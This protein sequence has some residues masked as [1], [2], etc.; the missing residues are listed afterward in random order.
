MF[1]KWQ[2]PDYLESVQEYNDSSTFSSFPHSQVYENIDFCT[3]SFSHIFQ[4][5]R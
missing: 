1:T 4:L 5:E 3:L 2:I